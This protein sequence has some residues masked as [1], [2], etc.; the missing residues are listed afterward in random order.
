MSGATHESLARAVTLTAG[1]NR[2]FGLVMAAFFL[3]LAILKLWLGAPGWTLSWLA[4]AA[5]FLGLAFVAPGLLQPLN[6]L[7]FRFGLLLHRVVS[8]LVMAILFFGVVTPIGLLMRLFGQRP[9]RLGFEKGA[10]SYWTARE[11]TQPGP[12]HKQY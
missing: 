11:A 3:V 12:M 7:W 5:L 2:G 9:L 6:R 10:A 4:A 1:P 8:P